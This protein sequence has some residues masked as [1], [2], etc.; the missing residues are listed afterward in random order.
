MKA[1]RPH[2]TGSK[3]VLF[4]HAHER[5]LLLTSDLDGFEPFI[6]LPAF[7]SRREDVFIGLSMLREDERDLHAIIHTLEKIATYPGV[8]DF[9]LDFVFEEDSEEIKAFKA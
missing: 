5:A 4:G 6:W 7:L 8:I 3:A 9:L 2:Q 1:Q